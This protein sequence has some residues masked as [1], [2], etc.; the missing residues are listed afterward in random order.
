MQVTINVDWRDVGQVT[1]DESGR[2]AFPTLPAVPGAYRF[3]LIGST[4]T[5]TYIG[6][7]WNLKRRAA[8]Y[9]GGA[10]RQPT[11][12]RMNVRMREHLG[13]G[14]RIEMPIITEAEIVV[15]VKSR[16]LDLGRHHR[17]ADHDTGEAGPAEVRHRDGGGAGDHPGGAR[18]D[19]RVRRPLGLRRHHDRRGLAISK[20]IHQ[21][22]IDVDEKGTGT[23]LFLGRVGD[24]SA[25]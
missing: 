23:I 13:A 5:S 24:P 9:R 6:E 20:V 17:C 15:G 8:L 25:R 18:H 10:P 7:G 22:N 3:R 16:P 1:L 21:A 2:L 12:H 4:Q 19:H 11:N 14:G